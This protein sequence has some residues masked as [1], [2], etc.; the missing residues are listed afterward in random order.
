MLK[1]RNHGSGAF[2]FF[3]K[4]FALQASPET[5]NAL[6]MQAL[7]CTE[8]WNTA[9]TQRRNKYSW[10][11]ANANTQIEEIQEIQALDIRFRDIPFSALQQ[12]I[13]D[14][15]QTYE[16]FLTANMA[17]K[18]HQR[19]TRPEVPQFLPEDTLYPLYYTTS[20]YTQHNHQIILQAHAEASRLPLTF[21]EDSLEQQLQQ[22]PDFWLSLEAE[23]EIHLCTQRPL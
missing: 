2:D 4:T 16:D 15:D 11:K 19:K 21:P 8:L 23:A 14:L 18:K 7:C 17:F 1:I 3:M 20:F 9:M 13:K 6:R 22:Q 12:V 5:Y 10:G